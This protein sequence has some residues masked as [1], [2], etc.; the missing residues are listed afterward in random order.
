MGDST[1]GKQSLVLPRWEASIA[2]LLL[3]M[4]KIAARQ[5]SSRW[6]SKPAD[7]SADSEAGVKKSSRLKRLTVTIAKTL[8]GNCRRARHTK[9]ASL[10]RILESLWCRVLIGPTST[11]T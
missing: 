11:S 8:I 9:K 2:P 7:H 1:G 4:P 3:K 6:I 10:K 5:D